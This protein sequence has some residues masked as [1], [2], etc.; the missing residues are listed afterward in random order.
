MLHEALFT[1]KHAL[2]SL[3]VLVVAIVTIILP[4]IIISIDN[5]NTQGI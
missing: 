3:A 5:Y 4:I 1:K 2:E